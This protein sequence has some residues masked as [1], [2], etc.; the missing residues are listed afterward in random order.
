MVTLAPSLQGG[1]GKVRD[2]MQRAALVQFLNKV[3]THHCSLIPRPFS[4]MMEPGLVIWLL[5]W[6][7]GVLKQM[8]YCSRQPFTWT[9]SHLCF[10][11]HSF[12]IPLLHC[13]PLPHF[14]GLPEHISPLL[15][16]F[17]LY[18]KC[19]FLF[20]SSQISSSPSRK[21]VPLSYCYNKIPESG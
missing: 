10:T 4:R 14:T 17:I 9:L 8:F 20:T 6:A 15:T 11:F 16:V 5:S 2:C 13:C 3:S 1:G 12:S 18:L 7:S 21:T 19:S